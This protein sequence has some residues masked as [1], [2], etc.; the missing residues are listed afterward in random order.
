MYILHLN[1][2]RYIAD[3]HTRPT[4]HL[5]TICRRKKTKT[6]IKKVKL[7]KID[8]VENSLDMSIGCNVYRAS[9]NITM[10]YVRCHIPMYGVVMICHIPGLHNIS[11]CRQ[12]WDTIISYFNG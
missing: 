6:E 9:E 7:R 8:D 5:H 4:G 3:G 1:T 11:V 2:T 10:Y 12:T